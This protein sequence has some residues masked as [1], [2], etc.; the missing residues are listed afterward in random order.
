[1]KAGKAD[2]RTFSNIPCGVA[3]PGSGPGS[4]SPLGTKARAVVVAYTSTKNVTIGWPMIHDLNGETHES[5]NRRS[6]GERSAR[7][8]L[9]AHSLM[10]LGLGFVEG[11]GDLGEGVGEGLVPVHVSTAGSEF[12]RAR[13]SEGSHDCGAG[14]LGEPRHLNHVGFG[15]ALDD[16]GSIGPGGGERTRGS[17]GG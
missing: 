1:M 17:N 16:R 7:A 4:V 2:P 9:R 8:S 11:L 12:R 14:C 13:I 10:C 3:P 15:C 5:S 6:S